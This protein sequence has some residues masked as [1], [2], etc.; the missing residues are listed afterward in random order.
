[1]GENVEILISEDNN[2][3][4]ITGSSAAKALFTSKVIFLKLHYTELDYSILTYILKNCSMD[5]GTEGKDEV[6]GYG[7]LDIDKANPESLYIC[8]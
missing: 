2:V 3:R 5:L 8:L 1:M 7:L 6:L 4:K